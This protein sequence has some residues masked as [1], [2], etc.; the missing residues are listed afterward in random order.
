MTTER[1]QE[2]VALLDRALERQ[3]EH[4]DDVTKGYRL[5]MNFALRTLQ[6]E[7]DEEL[8]QARADAPT[9]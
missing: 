4:N 5:A 7:L 2:I 3:A 8:E 9:L 6:R 1:L